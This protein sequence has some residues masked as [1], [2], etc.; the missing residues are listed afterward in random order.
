[1][2]P[3]ALITKQSL[4]VVAGLLLAA[5]VGAQTVPAADREFMTKAASGGMAEVAMGKMAQTKSASDKVKQFGERMEADHSKANEELRRIADANG[6]ELPS[7]LN[8]KTLSAI[9]AMNKLSATEF[10]RAYMQHMVDDHKKD[11]AAF[12][13]EAK[14]GKQTDVKSFAAETLPTLREHLQLAQSTARAV[15]K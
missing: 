7:A 13:K 2:Q 1:M 15:G 3:I 5:A 8:R 4:I 11:I 12:E 6:V 14:L 10:D 9:A